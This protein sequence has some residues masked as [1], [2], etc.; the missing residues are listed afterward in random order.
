M[1]V[2]ACCGYIDVYQRGEWGLAC[3]LVYVFGKCGAQIG[4]LFDLL[5]KN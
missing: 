3:I 5:A 4:P 2:S 1:V